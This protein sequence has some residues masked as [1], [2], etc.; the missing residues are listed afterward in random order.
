VTSRKTRPGDGIRKSYNLLAATF[1]AGETTL[2]L[3]KTAVLRALFHNGT[4]YQRQITTLT[5]IDRSTLSE[6]LKRLATDGMVGNVRLETDKRAIMV[7]I[8]PAGRKALKKADAAL[9][10]AEA[11]LMSLIPPPDRAPFLRGLRAIAERAG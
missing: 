10:R 7:T 3:P 2:T 11:I 6:I 4:L 9:T 1:E 8:T 5:G